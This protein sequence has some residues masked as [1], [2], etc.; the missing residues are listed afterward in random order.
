MKFDKNNG[1]ILNDLIQINNDRITGYQKAIEETEVID[2]DLRSIFQSMIQQSQENVAELTRYVQ[3][4]GTTPEM[5]TTLSG[6]IYRAWM[7]I[8]ASFSGFDKSAILDSCEYGED[9]ALKA[10]KDALADDGKERMPSYIK[11][12]IM[13]QKDK[14]TQSH[15]RIR[16]LRDTQITS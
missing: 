4:T 7:D 9:V 3:Q 2:A 1:E 13:E 5:G 14:L 8:K 16:M 10:Y 12:V 6:K 11:Q 15:D